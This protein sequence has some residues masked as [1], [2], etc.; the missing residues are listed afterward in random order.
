MKCSKCGF[1]NTSGVNFCVQCGTAL[2]QNSVAI[3]EPE[4]K[5]SWLP[6]AL[7]LLIGGP[8][9]AI[10]A[11][12]IWNSNW[13]VERK[14]KVS[15]VLAIGFFIAVFLFIGLVGV[16]ITIG[17]QKSRE[18]GKTSQAKNQDSQ[19]GFS[20]VN[21]ASQS[22][23]AAGISIPIEYQADT[24]NDGIPDFI[25]KQTDYDWQKDECL[26]KI[27]AC[28]T[29][30]LQSGGIKQKPK[31]IVILFDASGSMG[32]IVNG[33]A[34]ITAAKEALKNFANQVPSDVNVHLIAFGH[35]GSNST[36]DKNVSC[37]GVEDL[38]RLSPMDKPVFTSIVDQLLPRG[39]TALTTA[40]GY[41]Q[42]RL[43][44]HSGEANEVI[45]L[46]DGQETCGGDPL[47]AA[48]S[49]KEMG[50]KT[51][52]DVIAFAVSPADRQQLTKIAEAGGG[53]YKDVTTQGEI[54][55]LF[56][57]HSNRLAVTFYRACS[58]SQ[59]N[60]YASC[61]IWR[62]NS[63]LE[64]INA[65]QAKVG[66]DTTEGKILGL[67]RQ[68]T[69]EAIDQKRK[70]LYQILVNDVFEQNPNPN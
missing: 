58:A 65:L 21:P 39:W 59:F 67:V 41:A 2:G 68:Q 45:L 7:G 15:I 62:A 30:Y 60:E 3:A 26:E 44:P 31:N 5:K 23:I 10:V 12:F 32:E 6:V 27:G 33:V 16:L 4:N 34:K 40:M 56:I 36:A 49:L 50:A 66:F 43:I 35:K 24:N 42:V 69:Y 1:E 19:A 20:E 38:Y 52:V 55:N 53:E 61:S 9:G 22:G 63:A 8:I 14:K 13:P 54:E 25:E 11:Y 64:K 28:A 57:K 47:G 37:N 17:T 70:D 29:P 18:E 51:V 46:T 48:R